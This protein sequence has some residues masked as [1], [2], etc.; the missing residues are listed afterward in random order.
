M[1]AV[2]ELQVQEAAEFAERLADEA[3]TIALRYFRR[4]LAVE[5]KA[6]ASPVTA[7]DREIEAFIRER[8]RKRYPSHGLLGEEHGADAGSGGHTWVIDPIDGTKSFISGMPTFGTLIALL[9]GATP[10]LGIID[11]PAL[12]ERWAGIAGA[13]TRHNGVV[14]RARSCTRIEDAVLFA[15]TPDMFKGAARASFEAVSTSVRMRRF[16]ADC[17]GYALL[18]SG[19]IDAVMEAQ[20]QPYDFM[21]LVPVIEGAGGVITDW[22]GQPLG[23]NSD[24]RV[25]AAATPALHCEILKRLNR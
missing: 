20:L 6:D 7:A 9:D 4:P 8:I 19:Y 21:A 1:A 23:L 16:G 24:G 11:H 12:R 14:C 3:A 15:T 22:G 5:T 17:Y 13:P 10:V 2:E 25:I 18:A